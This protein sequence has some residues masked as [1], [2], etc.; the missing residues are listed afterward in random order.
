M[1]PTIVKSTTTMLEEWS[2]L[3]LSGKKEVDVFEEFR[4]LTGDAIARIAFG[5][6]YVEGNHIFNMQAEQMVLTTKVL[7][8]FYIPGFR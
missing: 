4:K 7:I 6:N 1:V 3:V 8:S 2:E 5:S